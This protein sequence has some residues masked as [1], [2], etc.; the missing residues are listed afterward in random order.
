MLTLNFALQDPVDGKN[1]AS[2]LTALNAVNSVG[3]ITLSSPRMSDPP[4]VD[5]AYLSHPA[6]RE[7]MIAGFKRNRQAWATLGPILASNDELVPGFNVTSDEQILKFIEGSIKPV[8]H[9]MA[10]NR[11]GKARDPRAVVDTKGRVYG[12]RG[13]RVVDASVFPFLLPGHI[14][15]SVYMLGEKIAEDILKGN[16]VKGY[17]GAG[18][19]TLA[20]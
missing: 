17:Y 15:A 14:Q 4:V 1:Y 5:P 11:M 18:N 20:Y 9:S 7:M 6:D 10:S 13:L 12:V 2:I 16:R 8:D 19:K 3:S